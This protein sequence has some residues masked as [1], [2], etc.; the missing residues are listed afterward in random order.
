MVEFL[1]GLVVIATL[2]FTVASMLSVG[3]G[4]TVAEILTPLRDAS[5]VIRALLANFV[6][7][8]LLALLCAHIV[9]L[10]PPLAV[11]LVLLG[12]SAGAPL[13]LLQVR[14]AEGNVGLSATLLVLLTSLTVV[15]VPL[16][17]PQIVTHPSL[18]GI[19]QGPVSAG[20]IAR[21]LV[22]SI[23]LP[24][25]IGLWVKARVPRWAA[26]LRPLMR[27]TAG[28]ALIVLV[29]ATFL[30]NLRSIVSLFGTGAILAGLLMILGGFLIGFTLGGADQ[31]ARVVLGLGTGQRNIA[32]ASVVATQSVDDPSTLVMVVVTS[33]L[34]MFVLFSVAALLRRWRKEPPK[35]PFR[36]RWGRRW[37]T[38][39]RA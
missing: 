25:G 38:P 39:V 3:F 21:P 28:L 24:L 32:A 5:K 8:P 30:A 9:S 36:K 33:I 16:V 2:V 17:I 29:A 14:T 15:Y 23:L 27:K 31:E 20:A 26:R 12:T 10:E 35:P 11:G 13:F 34:S 4:Y 1:R 6:L 7:V 22:L 19:V 18:T 37:G